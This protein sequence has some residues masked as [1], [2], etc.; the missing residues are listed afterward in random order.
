[1][2]SQE[3]FVQFK[4]FIE[5]QFTQANEVTV[6]SSAELQ[7]QL[8]TAN[9]VF[10]QSADDL[11]K[12]FDRAEKLWAET[13]VTVTQR[14]Q[15][16]EL[17]ITAVEI[18]AAQSASDIGDAKFTI[19]EIES[20]NYNAQFQTLH[21]TLMQE[22]TQIK[23]ELTAQR[24]RWNEADEQ[25]KRDM[26]D[27]NHR[28]GAG[29]G[30]GGPPRGGKDAT[31]IDP[32]YIQVGTYDGEGKS[33]GDYENWREELE[34]FI[35]KIF[36]HA[37]KIL[38]EIRKMRDDVTMEVFLD[39]ARKAGVN[40]NL[41]QWR[42][43]TADFE[44]KVFL[45]NKLKGNAMSIVKGVSSGFEMYRLLNLEFDKFNHGSEG[46]LSAELLKFVGSPSKNVREL[47][48]RMIEFNAAT[49][50][51]EERCGKAP[52]PTLMGSI[53]TN[54]LDLQTKREFLVEM[55]TK[56]TDILGNY[57]AMRS[58][59]L[60]LSLELTP[61]AMDLSALQAST[62]GA[63]IPVTSDAAN[64]ANAPSTNEDPAL[65]ALGPQTGQPKPP[66]PQIK[67]WTC[68]MTGHP[69]FLCPDAPKQPWQLNQQPGKGKGKGKSYGN[70]GKG[71]NPEGGSRGGGKGKGM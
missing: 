20:A 66:N 29:G 28:L 14:F 31:L 19:E 64:H 5:Q 69:S 47:K 9:E 33:R 44:I 16:H 49:K 6:N 56:N 57:Q 38:V 24:N 23:N 1:M 53:L 3:E 12:K 39:A 58:R 62:A 68:G 55:E 27:I 48:K 26:E 7:K 43:D 41:I 25:Y 15:A 60:K 35:N 2:V 40:S 42:F 50:K 34:D 21:G 36:P 13:D 70:Q 61:D 22:I 45:R 17:R 11:K 67:C 51:Y 65:A 30:D 10:V 32:K 4:S 63:N 18:T 59:I 52:D 71:F 54:M 37:K 8:S 46:L